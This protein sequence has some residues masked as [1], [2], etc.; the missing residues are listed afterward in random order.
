MLARQPR[1]TFVGAAKIEKDEIAIAR[2]LYRVRKRNEI[3]DAEICCFTRR[4]DCVVR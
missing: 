3:N 2:R 4:Q 1:V